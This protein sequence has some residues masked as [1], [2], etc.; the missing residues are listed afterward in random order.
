M[1]IPKRTGR[2]PGPQQLIAVRGVSLS[3]ADWARVLGFETNSPLLRAA[4]EGVSYEEAVEQYL[5]QIRNDPWS[6]VVEVHGVR[7]TIAQ[8]S[9][10]LGLGRGTLAAAIAK[11]RLDAAEYIAAKLRELGRRDP[12]TART[13]P[14]S[15]EELALAR[16][17]IARREQGA[18]L[19][20]LEAEF[21]ISDSSAAYLLKRYER[22]QRAATGEAPA[23][24][25]VDE[26]VKLRAEGLTLSQIARRAGIT[27]QAVHQILRK[28]TRT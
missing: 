16:A 5:S 8:W 21:S 25:T 13:K 28:H 15:D 17:M 9:E 4:R 24:L 11:S 27:R 7:A 23:A 2:P 26:M 6:K 1:T 18:T 3:L 14:L 12:P 22:S 20:D 10:L 19:A